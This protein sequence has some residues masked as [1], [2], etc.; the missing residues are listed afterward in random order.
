MKFP[1]I[2]LRL[3]L[4]ILFIVIVALLHSYSKVLL[5]KVRDETET[6]FLPAFK[7]QLWKH[8]KFHNA[9]DFHHRPYKYQFLQK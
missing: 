3:C 5:T 6:F 9:N 1:R 8:R 4:Y 2:R 7:R